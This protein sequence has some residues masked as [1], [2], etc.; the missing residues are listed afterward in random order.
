MKKKI[1]SDKIQTQDKGILPEEKQAILKAR[2]KELA[3][4]EKDKAVEQD[5][6]EVIR[7]GLASETYGIETAFVREVFPLKS[8]ARLPGLPDF[9]HGIVNIRGQIVSVIDLKKFFNLPEKEPGEQNK[10][11]IIYNDQTEFGILAD[12]IYGTGQVKIK[13]LQT[14]IPGSG[15]VE[16]EYLKGITSDHLIMLDTKKILE[17]KKMIVNQKTE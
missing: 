1:G 7:F 12:I 16:S 4:G 8:C 10:V 11:I 14:S 6:Q 3:K 5:V 9:I 17:D 13:N 2:A 15:S